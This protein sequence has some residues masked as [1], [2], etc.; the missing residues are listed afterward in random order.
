MD[1]AEEI[2]GRQPS[3]GEICPRSLAEDAAGTETLFQHPELVSIMEVESKRSSSEAEHMDV[4]ETWR[5]YQLMPVWMKLRK[6][7][8]FHLLP[9]KWK[10]VI[11]KN[12]FEETRPPLNKPNPYPS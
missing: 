6:D 7:T 10:L 4:E 1:V 2:Y 3:V 9:I 12:S 5:L 11:S 8:D